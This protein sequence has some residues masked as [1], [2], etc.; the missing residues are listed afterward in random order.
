M[1]H[2]I[3]VYLAFYDLI[4]SLHDNNLLTSFASLYG[5]NFIIFSLERV[6]KS[7]LLYDQMKKFF[8]IR[9]RIK[10]VISYAD[11][12]LASSCVIGLC[13]TEGLINSVS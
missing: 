9:E 4:A 8:L 3:R 13:P 1:D 2:V 7:F 11:V 6:I 10:Q 12:L 5:N